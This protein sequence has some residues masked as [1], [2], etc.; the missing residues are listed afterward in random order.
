LP[1]LE[2][3]K[4]D[5]EIYGKGI[6]RLEEL[7]QELRGLNTKGRGKE[8][9]AIESNLKNVSAIPKIEKQLEVLK[10]KIHGKT[11]PVKRKVTTISSIEKHISEL[12]ELVMHKHK[13][14]TKPLTKDE[15]EDIHEIP[16][17]DKGIKDVKY[18]IE[19][20][21]KR[22]KPIPKKY[23]E[24]IKEIPKI[25]KYLVELKAEIEK[26][27]K[28]IPSSK[29]D[30]EVGLTVQKYFDDMLLNIKY[31]FSNILK[32]KKNSLKEEVNLEL[33]NDKNK[34]SE[35]HKALVQS[36]AEK[37]H[38]KVQTE[39]KKEVGSSLK[40]IIDGKIARIKNILEKESNKKLENK[41]IDL[42][43]RSNKELK[44]KE[45]QLKKDFGNKLNKNTIL[46][47]KKEITIKK[48]YKNL[49]K[50]L[51][52]RFN[53]ELKK[54]K[55]DL[56]IKYSKEFKNKKLL[57]IK[58]LKNRELALNDNT[59]QLNIKE[60]MFKEKYRILEKSLNKKVNEEIKNEDKRIKNAYKKRFLNLNNALDIYKKKEKNMRENIY[61]TIN[62]EL[63]KSY[64]IKLMKKK[65]ALKSRL[66][67]END[68]KL[69]TQLMELKREIKA[70]MHLKYE[71]K[72]QSR[73]SELDSSAKERIKHKEVELQNKFEDELNRRKLELK[74]ELK[75]SLKNIL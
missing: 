52:N 27:S 32:A 60:N 31:E 36:F 65:V 17:I 72:F 42:I 57:V 56:K 66:Q 49:D 59:N 70:E 47:N 55:E 19:S 45:G 68:E 64:K 21:S 14:V 33:V 16:K 18:T 38:H 41:R 7:K 25:E 2:T 44:I 54:K 30:G 5:F 1:D 4:R 53:E 69:T 61:R 48:G 62:L 9:K 40:H 43:K 11:K 3:I 15:L 39:L 12:K 28:K 8:V 75:K 29:I 63:L 26:K 24:N 67:K 35:K 22:K 6:Q 10:R 34:L 50:S 73:K 71:N 37:Y 74:E 23:L 58:E 13:L 20:L 51:K 46:L